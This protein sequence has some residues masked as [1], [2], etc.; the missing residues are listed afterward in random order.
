ML[1]VKFFFGLSDFSGSSSSLCLPQVTAAHHAVEDDQ[2]FAHA[3]CYSHLGFLACLNEAG[4]KS[5]DNS[6]PSNG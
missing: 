6:V 5:F 4:V 1:P 3:S 2:Q